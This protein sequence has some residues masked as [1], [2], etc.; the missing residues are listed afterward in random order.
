MGIL[1]WS[2]QKHITVSEIPLK[3]LLAF[4]MATIPVVF[5]YSSILYIEPPAIL[6]MTLVCLDIKDL[7]HENAGKLTQNPNWYALIL[8]GFI[9]ETATPFLLC[10]L[11][12]REIIQLQKWFTTE[13]EKPLASFLAV[14][15]RIIFSVLAPAFLYLYFRSDLTST[16]SYIPHLLNLFDPSI[17][18]LIGRSLVEQ[19]GPFLLFFLCGCIL[20]IT[21]RKYSILLCQLLLITITLVFYITDNKILIGYSRF[22]LSILPPILT[23]AS[24]FIGW[25]FLQKHIVGI[26]LVLSALVVNLIISPVYLDGTK[27]P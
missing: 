11:V 17:Y 5:Y 1:A 13:Q 12:C 14:E 24:M 7:T 15:L 8:I 18:P 19:F 23:V 10:F 4:G 2:F 21:R 20:L 22:D 27:M 26:A 9:K 16:R 3:L 6:L 25:I